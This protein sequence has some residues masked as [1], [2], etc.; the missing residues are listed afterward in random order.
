MNLELDR[1][2]APF[3]L[4]GLVHQ[5]VDTVASDP[6]GQANHA[7]TYAPL[8]TAELE[9]LSEIEMSQDL[10]DKMHAT[11]HLGGE[12]LRHYDLWLQHNPPTYKVLETEFWLNVPLGVEVHGHQAYFVGR[13]DGLAT[14][15]EGELTILEYKTAARL[16]D[17]NDLKL[18]F[19]GL[20]YLAAAQQ[21]GSLPGRRAKARGLLFIYMLKK[22]AKPP[23]VLQNGSLSVNKRQGTSYELYVEALEDMGLDPSEYG[24]MLLYL[25][26]Q[27]QYFQRTTISPTP[28]ALEATWKDLQTLAREMLNPQVHIYPNP[29]YFPWK[30]NNCWYKDP[31]DLRRQ[32]IDPAPL[33]RSAYRE[34]ERREHG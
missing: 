5:A 30:C 6:A 17:P 4:G 11:V 28:E 22:V 12:M 10:E 32:G 15:A 3:V 16:K 2:Y 18:D 25:S 23:T 24:K 27:C 14:D 7:G 26:T 1:P 33:L 19:Q 31:C 21:L 34:R 20:A 29:G 8:A 13:T 9:R